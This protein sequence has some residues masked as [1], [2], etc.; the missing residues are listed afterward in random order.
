MIIL[1][2]NSVFISYSGTVLYNCVNP[3]KCWSKLMSWL[4]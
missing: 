3:K 2:T 4:S 1:N